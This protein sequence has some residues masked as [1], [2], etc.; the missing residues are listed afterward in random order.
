MGGKAIKKVQVSRIN[1]EIYEKI[2]LDIKEKFSSY[3]QIDF[4]YDV[5]GK[6]SHGDLDVLY[7]ILDKSVRI[8]DLIIE[9]YNPEEI[10]SNGDVISFAYNIDEEYYQVD[11]IK[12]KSIP[13]SKFY[14]SYGDLGGILGRISKFYGLTYGAD[15]MWLSL[16]SQTVNQ[17]LKKTDNPD[18]VDSLEKLDTTWNLGDIALTSDPEEICCYL[19]LDYTKWIN[20]FDTEEKIFDWVKS[21]KYFTP[22]IFQSL[23]SVHR[24]RVNLRPFYQKF[25]LSIKGNI[26]FDLT[27]NSEISINN[28]L[29]AIIY[30]NKTEE[31]K[32]LLVKYKINKERKEKFNG[33]LIMDLGLVDNQ[34][35]LGKFISEF[36][37]YINNKFNSGFEEWLDTQTNSQVIDILQN[38]LIK[39]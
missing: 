26:E 28:Q 6:T 7:K 14:F 11:F 37:S 24:R 25:V 4:S 18:L 35:L 12:C 23:N 38:F 39:Q 21:S 19:D 29:E 1:L 9:T 2:K 16:Y 10:V 30:F 3:A 5:P 33:N 34:Q 15:G 27:P 36:K 31:L 22:E 20:G 17:Y 8:R 13:M 32:N